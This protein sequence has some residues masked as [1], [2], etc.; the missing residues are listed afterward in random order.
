M[1]LEDQNTMNESANQRYAHSTYI[2]VRYT[3]ICPIA[4]SGKRKGYWLIGKAQSA[5]V[6]NQPP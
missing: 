3:F 5:E 1:R 4:V 2:N 6:E